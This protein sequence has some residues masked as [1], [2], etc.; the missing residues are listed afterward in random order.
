METTPAPN[1][2]RVF[3][4]GPRNVFRRR[5]RTRHAD[6]IRCA[7]VAVYLAVLERSIPGVTWMFEGAAGRFGQDM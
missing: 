1:P 2:Y 3:A 5:E 7:A 4:L 6:G